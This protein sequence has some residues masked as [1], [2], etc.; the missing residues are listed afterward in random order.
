MWSELNTRRDKRR[1]AGMHAHAD[2]HTHIHTYTIIYCIYICNHI[3]IYVHGY[4]PYLHHTKHFHTI[5]GLVTHVHRHN[6]PLPTIRPQ[7]QQP[8]PHLGPPFNQQ[9]RGLSSELFGTVNDF[10]QEMTVLSA[11]AAR[12]FLGDLDRWRYYR[13]STHAVFD[14][15]SKCCSGACP[16]GVRGDV[17]R[18]PEFTFQTLCFPLRATDSTSVMKT[19]HGSCHLSR[20]KY[21]WLHCFM[22]S[23]TLLQLA[24]VG[25][26]WQDRIALLL[27]Q[28]D[29][30]TSWAG[31]GVEFV[32]GS[33]NNMVPLTVDWQ[34]WFPKRSLRNGS[35]EPRNGTWSTVVLLSA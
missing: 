29:L 10:C 2:M 3:D 6:V 17:Y 31:T 11:T 19:M 18:H 22:S 12:P 21:Q 25:G 8:L 34:M 33:I 4:I 26:H 35:H 13:G 28:P 1:Q 15:V 30:S 14:A 7:M 32:T 5:P 20:T 27:C 9:S 24:E 16:V 23:V